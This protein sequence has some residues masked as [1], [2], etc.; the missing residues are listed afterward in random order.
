MNYSVYAV[1]YRE[2]GETC[3]SEPSDVTVE[4]TAVPENSVETLL[5]PNPASNSF[6][7]EGNIK[8]IKVFDMLGQRVYQG[9]DNVVDVT[10]WPEGV[11]FVRILGEND[12]VLVVRFVKR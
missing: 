2:G 4:V 5:Y 1:Y 7:V 8:E 3:Q 11:Y 9:S 6:T 12:A 10:S